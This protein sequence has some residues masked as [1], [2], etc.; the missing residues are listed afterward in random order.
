[1]VKDFKM[2]SHESDGKKVKWSNLG[3]GFVAFLIIAAIFELSNFSY[4]LFILRAS[5]LGVIAAL[6]PIIYL[7]YNSVYAALAQPLGSLSD[8]IGKKTVLFLGY[9]LAAFMCFGFARADQP[10]YAWLLFAVYGIVSTVT[11]TVPRA[12]VADFVSSERRGTAYGIYYMLIGAVAFPTSAIAGLLWDNFG[13][14]AAFNYGAV[15]A[16]VA[17]VLVLL[18]LPGRVKL[19]RAA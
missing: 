8:R 6:I 11:N 19:T 14:A 13:A 7:L 15:L 17:A 3:D 16:F 10:F 4:A 18:F 1:M 5:N 12:L 2:H 9:L